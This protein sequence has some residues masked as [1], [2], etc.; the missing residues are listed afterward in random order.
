MYPTEPR[1]LTTAAI[2]N[3]ENVIRVIDSA[4]ASL[5]AMRN[6]LLNED[7]QALE[8]RLVRARE[9]RQVWLQGRMV[10]DWA[11]EETTT[12]EAPTASER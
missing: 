3:R 5:N 10:A 6:D 9:G 2:L 7:D 8:E 12:V 11:A 1:T 4:V